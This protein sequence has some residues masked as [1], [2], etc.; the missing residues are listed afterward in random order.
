MKEYSIKFTKQNLPLLKT[1]RTIRALRKRGNYIEAT[2]ERF[3]SHFSMLKERMQNYPSKIYSFGVPV[4]DLFVGRIF[5]AKQEIHLSPV[6][7]IY[8]FNE[9]LH[10]KA[11]K[12]PTSFV[13]KNLSK[14]ELEHRKNN[15]NYML[16]KNDHEEA[17]DM[18]YFNDKGVSFDF[19]EVEDAADGATN[20]E[21][22]LRKLR[23]CILRVKIVNVRE[24]EKVSKLAR[25][26]IL[27]VVSEMCIK[28]N[29]RF[30]LKSK[31]YPKDL[32]S[33]REKILELFKYQDEIKC[34]VGDGQDRMLINEICKKEGN[35]YTLKGYKED[36]ELISKKTD[37]EKVILEHG[38]VSL[39]KLSKLVNLDEDEIREIV[40]ENKNIITLVNK[41]YTVRKDD[42]PKDMRNIVIDFLVKQEFLKRNDISQVYFN[43]TGEEPNIFG[44]N[45]VM[46]E[47]CVNKGNNWIIKNGN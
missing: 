32:R 42:N 2:T 18:V 8:H 11:P 6:D 40:A 34:F 25:D 15:I 23:M 26:A 1:P 12:Q 39:S 41:T 24:L 17:V 45:K 35:Y 44:Y 36:I 19:Q 3:E 22:S 30:L 28:M 43:L 5:H 20:E 13:M 7:T 27:G 31:Y 9:K 16:K 10:S 33:K 29:S 46:R 37:L 47:F 38:M 4:K 21:G 14:E